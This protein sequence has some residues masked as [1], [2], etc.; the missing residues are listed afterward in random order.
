[1]VPGPKTASD[2]IRLPTAL[3]WP[4]LQPPRV[5]VAY[6]ARYTAG[7]SALSLQT[8]VEAL[9]REQYE[10]VILCH[11]LRD[12]GWAA[13][14]E[15]AQVPVI[16]LVAPW[17][18]ARPGLSELNLN[19][20]LRSDGLPGL[21]RRTRGTVRAVEGLLRLDW[22]W[23][24]ALARQLRR[25]RP[26]LVHCNNG[27]RAHRLD[28]LLCR[29]LGLPVI[30]HVRNFEALSAVE[31]L[32]ARGVWR[33]IYISRAIAADF[34]RQGIPARRGEVI[35]NALSEGALA[36]A[37]PVARTELG[38]GPEHYLV[39][40]VGRL[41]P[42][43]GQDMF[44]RAIAQAARRLPQVRALIVGAADDNDRSR[45]FAAELHA[46]ANSLG[47]AQQVIFTG[48]RPDVQSVM[49]AADVVVHTAVTPEPFGRVLIEALAAGCPVIA[50][51]AGGVL[52]ILEHE[53]T[54]LIVPPNDSQA[55]ADSLLRLAADP[56]LRARLGA[57]GRQQASLRFNAPE[58]ARQV[59]AL[60]RLALD[61]SAA[62]DGGA[63]R[64]G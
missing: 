2:A 7:G 27:L 38:C 64:P 55:L 45:A 1:M 62:R 56:A 54:G 19:A 59:T 58:H 31:R 30:C 11:A 63:A 24:P 6:L 10:A 48:H 29:M 57:A 14:L 23:Q 34:E 16:G 41:V 21:I 36:P 61:A 25:L 39:A 8:L 49:A 4:A 15:A 43:K 40:N 44:L 32:A 50:A 28:I 53:V 17:R 13:A 9:D 3:E 22:R 42:W 47:L 60:Y 26:A 46:L 51:G 20:R 18:A 52:E 37:A 35:P 5:R 33:F 12:P